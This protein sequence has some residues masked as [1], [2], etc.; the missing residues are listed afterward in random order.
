MIA[1]TPATQVVTNY[2]LV[3]AVEAP[4]PAQ[5]YW[6]PQNL[7]YTPLPVPQMV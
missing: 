1:P 2:K 3:E 6:Y 7:E 5:Q 4:Q